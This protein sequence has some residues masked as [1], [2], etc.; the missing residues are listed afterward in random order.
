MFCFARFLL[1]AF[2]LTATCAS[3]KCSGEEKIHEHANAVQLI[4][5]A[6]SSHGAG[7]IEEA[8]FLF[9][10]AQIRY[11]IDKEVYPPIGKGGNS[12]GVLVGA[13]ASSAKQVILPALNGDPT[14]SAN[15]IKRLTKWTPKFIE[16][17]DPGWKYKER[18]NDKES[19]AILVEV[20]DSI[21]SSLQQKSRLL[22]N[23]K[24][25]AFSNQV[26][27]INGVRQR[28]MI[29]LNKP[30]GRNKIS[31]ELESEYREAMVKKKQIAI[32]MKEIEWDLNPESR[33]HHIVKWEA[34]DYF[35]DS[36][37]IE[38]C[39]AIENNDVKEMERLILAGADVNS[40]GKQGMTLLLWAFPDRKI[41]RFEC[42]LKHGANPYVVM[43]SDFGAKN[44][45][46][47]PYPH[48]SRS[49]ED[50]GCEVGQSITHLACR[51]PMT[52]YMRI[53]FSNSGN[54]NLLNA[55]TK[56][57][58][59]DIVI[60]RFLPDI[61]ER[62][63]LLVKHNANLNRYYENELT[64]PAKKAVHTNRY[65]IA[66]YLLQ[67]GASYEIYEAKRKR[68]LIH[69][70]M[71]DQFMLRHFSTEKTADFNAL[72]EWLKNHGES[73]NDAIEY[74]KKEGTWG[75]KLKQEKEQ[76]ERHAKTLANKES[77]K[78]KK[79]ARKKLNFTDRPKT[80]Q[81]LV[82]SLTEE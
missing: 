52:Q 55:K 29:E 22:S 57:A 33:W 34:K 74:L 26:G 43:E 24:Y 23:E 31:A 66:L 40:V 54:A 72:V 44:R 10:A 53:V 1:Y 49:L 4:L 8:G 28:Y 19:Q 17:Y 18:L 36:L 7:D 65:D 15:V 79:L 61:K 59:I 78:Q 27:E 2:I 12:P 73:P 48:G 21:T 41:E 39:Q 25:Q 32:Q 67:S 13:L 45:P 80:P 68:K 51:S 81:E 14:A 82:A 58:P 20:F 30:E 56:A 11:K 69:Y 76:A 6:T 16:E 60:S 50:R 9:Y 38:L 47:H 37:T 3:N 71:L 63:E 75:A 46:L 64:Y 35:Q 5:A 77:L 62:V 70:V 42:L